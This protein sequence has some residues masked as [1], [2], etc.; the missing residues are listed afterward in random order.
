MTHPYILVIIDMQECFTEARHQP[1]VNCILN[2]IDEAK[3]NQAYIFVVKIINQGEIISEIN[4][5]IKECNFVANISCTDEDKSKYILNEIKKLSLSTKYIK[6]C[7]VNTDQCVLYTV[8]SLSK[9][10]YH[11]NVISEG[12]NCSHRLNNNP[13]TSHYKALSKMAGMNNVLVIK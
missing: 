12:C 2:L 10:T 13:G 1:T 11:I 8:A 3:N 5:K 4:E 7:G 6:L 9:T